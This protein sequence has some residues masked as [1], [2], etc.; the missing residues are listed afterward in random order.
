M[1]GQ[2]IWQLFSP[3]LIYI[4]SFSVAENTLIKLKHVDK[5]GISN[6]SNLSSISQYKDQ[7]SENNLQQISK[8]ITVKIVSKRLLGSGALLKKEGRFYTVI[9][10]AHVLKNANLP[11]QVQTNDGRLYVAKL[12]KEINYKNKDLAILQFKSNVAYQTGLLGKSDDL[13]VGNNIFV[14]GFTT[15]SYDDKRFIFTTGQISLMLD[16]PLEQGYQIG[17]TNDVSKGMSGAP[18]INS[19]GKV[20]GIHG[21]SKNP[22]WDAPE[23]YEDGSEPS[24]PVQEIIYRSSFAIPI[25]AVIQLAPKF[26]THAEIN[27]SHQNEYQSND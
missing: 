10:N 17:Y 20:V 9:T 11:Y 1:N 22:L 14:G 15:E 23:S 21:W 18:V 27:N 8:N 24:K 13:V 19:Q 16:K 2:F 3:I 12:A 25:E 26:V 4:S 5:I 6:S 7:I